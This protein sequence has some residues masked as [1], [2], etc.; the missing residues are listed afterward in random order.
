[1]TE[2][3]KSD[4]RCRRQCKIGRESSRIRSPRCALRRIHKRRTAPCEVQ[5]DAS[6]F[7]DKEG[8]TPFDAG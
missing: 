8:L 4:W 2:M 6:T 1:M 3:C 7:A 5:G